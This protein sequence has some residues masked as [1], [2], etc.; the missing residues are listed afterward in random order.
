MRNL[1]DTKSTSEALL[2]AGRTL[3]TA[4]LNKCIV[5][6]NKS[7]AQKL[8]LLLGAKALLLRRLRLIDDEPAMIEVS[9]ISHERFPWADKHDFA[10]KS[11]YEAL[12]ESGAH[13][14]G[15]R[16]TIGITYANPEE[17]E[18]LGIAEN[19]PLFFLSGV[20]F[21]S[22]G[23]PIEYFETVARSDKLRFKSTLIRTEG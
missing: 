22:G 16:E 1:Q 9:Y 19:A 4:E 17:A 11:L 8:H 13:I 18:L 10:E 20:A 3:R 6:C 21:G 2:S 15:G 23:E 7:V 12:R 5:E 14:E